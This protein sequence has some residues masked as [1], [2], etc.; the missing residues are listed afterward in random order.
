MLTVLGGLAEFEREL[1]RARTGE[2]RKRAK[3]SGVRFGR[4]HKLTPHQRQEALAR[5]EAGE[6]LMDIAR[7]Y[8][9]SHPTI[10]RLYLPDRGV[11]GEV[12]LWL[13]Q[14]CLVFRVRM[15]RK[16]SILNRFYLQ[17]GA[18]STRPR[19]QLNAPGPSI[20]FLTGTHPGVRCPRSETCRAKGNTMQVPS[21]LQRAV[22]A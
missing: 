17:T 21:M 3:E 20:R 15:I 8:G 1:I 18:Y 4:P 7:S 19:H 14:P 12:S 6:T 22:A 10:S 11:A 5:R 16:W 13:R 2:G 9:V